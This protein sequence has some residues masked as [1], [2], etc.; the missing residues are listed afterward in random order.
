M[1]HYPALAFAA[2]FGARL[3]P[4]S[5]ASL[6]IDAALLHQ[7]THRAIRQGDVCWLKQWLM[8][9]QDSEIPDPQSS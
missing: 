4:I 6:Q 8:R 7:G 1:A 3:S 5:V 2:T 9:R